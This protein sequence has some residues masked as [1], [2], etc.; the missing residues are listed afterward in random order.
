MAWLARDKDNDLH[1]YTDK[2]ERV[3][4]W[5]VWISKNSNFAKLS[6]NADSELI[7]RTITW[8]DEPVEI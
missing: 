6:D 5:S 1:V 7:N 4:M 2:P 3:E 8:K